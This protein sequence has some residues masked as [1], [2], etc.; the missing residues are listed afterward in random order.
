M[1]H[2]AVMAVKGG[3]IETGMNGASWLVCNSVCVLRENGMG[4]FHR[5]VFA[6]G[7][8]ILTK[9]TSDLGWGA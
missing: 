1:S 5:D 6:I 9:L 2:T 8:G 4:E 3:C 7:S